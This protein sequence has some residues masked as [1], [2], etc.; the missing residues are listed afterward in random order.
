MRRMKHRNNKNDVSIISRLSRRTSREPS[1]EELGRPEPF[2]KAPSSNNI[3][4]NAKVHSP[5]S[6]NGWHGN[7]T[8]MK[9]SSLEAKWRKKGVQYNA[10]NM[11]CTMFSVQYAVYSVQCMVCSVHC[12]LYTVKCT[13]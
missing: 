8:K 2:T 6:S 4:G 12:T 10:Y 3:I 5:P 7:G 9:D 11:L 13:Q 1:D